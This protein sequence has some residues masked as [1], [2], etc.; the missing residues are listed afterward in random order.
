MTKKRRQNDETP[1]P[2]GKIVKIG[3]VPER[4]YNE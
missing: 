3:Y 4:G 1:S 2:A